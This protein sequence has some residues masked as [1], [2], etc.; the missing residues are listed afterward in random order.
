MRLWEKAMALE[1]SRATVKDGAHG[2]VTR[3]R[4]NP[5]VAAPLVACL[6]AEPLAGSLLGR[7]LASVLGPAMGDAEVVRA[8]LTGLVV[9]ALAGGIALGVVVPTLARLGPQIGAAGASDVDRGCAVLLLPLTLAFTGALAV[10]LPIGAAVVEASPGGLG[11]LPPVLAMLLTAGISGGALASSLRGGTLLARAVTA[12]AAG[13]SIGAAVLVGGPAAV[14]AVASVDGEPASA[15]RSVG[16]LVVGA[17]TTIAWGRLLIRIED[18]DAGGASAAWLNPRSAVPATFVAAARILAR[19]ADLRA[20]LLG[21]TG[22]GV[23][24][25]AIAFL[26]DAPPPTGMALGSSGAVLAAAPCAVAVGGALREA[27]HVWVLATARTAVALAWLAAAGIVTLAPAG[28]A[29]AAAVAAGGG[30]VSDALPALGVAAGVCAAGLAA[31]ALLPWHGGRI[32][33]QAASLGLFAALCAALSLVSALVGPRLS[34]LG[35]PPAF[36]A[37]SVLALALAGALGSM[38]RNLEPVR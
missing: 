1:L 29:C 9:A 8:L 28:L 35:V 10:A 7:Q 2:L 13:V 21:G 23:A 22:I 27:E 11:S 38:L 15:W 24:G 33:E 26:V 30:Q 20:A 17:L 12:I 19:R 32:I 25:V 37:A 34:A 5:K 36:S 31:G 16:V 3:L 6:A 14:A 4:T 18:A